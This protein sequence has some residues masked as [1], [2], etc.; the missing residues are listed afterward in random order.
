[1]YESRRAVRCDLPSIDRSFED[2]QV[3]FNASQRTSEPY[4]TIVS[5]MASTMFDETSIKLPP[6]QQKLPLLLLAL[7]GCLE[8]FSAALVII[9]EIFIFDVAIGVWCGFV[10]ALA[11]AATLIFGSFIHAYTRSITVRSFVLVTISDRERHQS[12]TVLIFQL[13]GV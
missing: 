4:E 8:V 12:S 13:I 11:G 6:F 9:L 7:L 10:Y 3:S 1:M 5:P 2:Q